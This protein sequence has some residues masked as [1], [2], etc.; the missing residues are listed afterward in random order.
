[1][2]PELELLLLARSVEVACHQ[3]ALVVVAG[4]RLLQALVERLR[5]LVVEWVKEVDAILVRLVR[6][7]GVEAVLHQV[8]KLGLGHVLLVG[9]QEDD[10]GPDDTKLLRI[11]LQKEGKQL[12]VKRLVHVK[13]PLCHVPGGGIGRHH[14]E[15]KHLKRK[16]TVKA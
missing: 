10:V 2:L 1:M 15:R 5:V 4:G 7:V 3:L 8:L 12:L 16:A 9:L 6:E 13:L 11:L 14:V